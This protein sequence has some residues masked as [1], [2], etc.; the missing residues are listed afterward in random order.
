[1]PK[2]K[3]FLYTLIASFLL[4]SC[5]DTNVISN[6]NEKNTESDKIILTPEEFTSIAYDAPQELSD[7]EI[8]NVISD[9]KNNI[10]TKKVATT[11]NSKL[12]KVA[13]KKKYYI[14][15]NN[16]IIETI[17]QLVHQYPMNSLYLY[18]MLS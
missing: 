5:T 1:M 6:F 4:L 9:F 3:Y 11:R 12:S 13:I 15:Q 17:T 7:E 16:N 10:E 8:T 2:N 18:L 14:T